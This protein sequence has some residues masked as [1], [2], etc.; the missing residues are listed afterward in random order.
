MNTL[1][2][3]AGCSTCKKAVKWLKENGVEHILVDLKS[4]PPSEA[5]LGDLHARSGLPVKKFFNTSGR[6]YRDGKFGDR[7]ADASDETAISWLA[8]DGML[9]KRPI[10]DSGESVQIGFRSGEFEV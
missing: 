8:S 1:Y 10:F 2:W 5:V 3:Y 6:S 9:I 4:D 7:L